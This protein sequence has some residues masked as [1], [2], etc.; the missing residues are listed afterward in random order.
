M[1]TDA[2]VN[3]LQRALREVVNEMFNKNIF[4]ILLEEHHIVWKNNLKK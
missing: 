1:Y 3:I 4:Y 2:I